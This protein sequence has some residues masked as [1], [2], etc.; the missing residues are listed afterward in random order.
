MCVNPKSRSIVKTY[1]YEWKRSSKYLDKYNIYSCLF[2][3]VV[4]VFQ[5]ICLLMFSECHLHLITKQEI[6]FS[7][8]AD[9]PVTLVRL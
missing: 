2:A 6:E 9:G 4:C 5:K 8:C 1:Y 3:V 7:P